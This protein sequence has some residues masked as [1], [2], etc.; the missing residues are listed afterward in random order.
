MDNNTLNE[1]ELK[2]IIK[3]IIKNIKPVEVLGKIHPKLKTVY[4]DRLYHYKDEN[5]DNIGY[6]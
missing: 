1:N 4:E 6:I 5:S 3:Q 2:I